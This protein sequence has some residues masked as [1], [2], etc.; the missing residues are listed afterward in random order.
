VPSYRTLERAVS[1]LAYA[2]TYGA[3]LARPPGIVPDLPGVDRS[4]AHTAL[5]AMRQPADP[6]RALTDDELRTLLACY[7]IELVDFQ[8]VNSAAEAVTAAARIG[9]PAVLKSFDESLRHQLDQSGVRL[10]LSNSDQLN[11]AYDDLSAV[12]GPWL[13]V[14]AMV[15]RDRTVVATEFRVTADPS[16]GALISFGIGGVATELLDDRAYR[17]VPLTDTDAAD[18]IGAPQAAPLLDGYRGTRIVAREP[19]IELALRLSALADDL[20]EVS[21]LELL[22]VLAGPAGIAVTSGTGR[23]GPRPA[24]PDARRRLR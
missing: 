5:A 12:A 10:G 21:Q 22:P 17:A 8:S 2:V 4:A 7:G 23:I 9:Y 6:E 3:W 24:Q 16:F 18:L 20:P 15:P 1:A 14:Q 19:L 11:A 13:Y